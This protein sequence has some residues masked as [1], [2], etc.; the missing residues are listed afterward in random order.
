MCVCVEFR[1]HESCDRT[2]VKTWVG[3][4]LYTARVKLMFLTTGSPRANK[5]KMNG[6]QSTEAETLRRAGAQAEVITTDC[7]SYIIVRCHWPG[8]RCGRVVLSRFPIVYARSHNMLNGHC[9]CT[10]HTTHIIYN[11]II[12]LCSTAAN[13]I[14]IFI[15]PTRLYIILLYILYYTSTLYIVGIYVINTHM[16]Y[17]IYLYR[18]II[19]TSWIQN[20]YRL[21][22]L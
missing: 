6:A 5:W 17:F 9:C 2:T 3:I 1:S 22:S 4:L 13:P 19:L 21:F 16:L 20:V 15:L 11:I 8:R 10:W 12:I 7:S 14:D 18:K